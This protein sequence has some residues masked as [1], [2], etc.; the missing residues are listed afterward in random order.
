MLI[1]VSANGRAASSN[2]FTLCDHVT[3]TFDLIL[4]DGRGIV[5]DDLCAKFDDFSYSH[6]GFI[7]RT[8][9]QTDRIT[10]GGDRYTHTTTVGV[11][12]YAMSRPIAIW[13]VV[14]LN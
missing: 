9:R 14:P 5:K 8:D 6:F 12:N 3:M 1:Y 11:S 2:T 10:V 13:T 4:I 7:V